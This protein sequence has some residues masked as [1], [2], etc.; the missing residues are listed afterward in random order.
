MKRNLLLALP[1]LAVVAL[2]AWWFR[3]PART[4]GSAF[5][6]DRS[7]TV[8]SSLAQ[9][10]RPLA[11]L[12]YGDKVEILSRRNENAQV[13]VHESVVGWVDGN[14]LM[15][16]ELWLKSAQLLERARALPLQSRGRTKVKTNLRAEPG[17]AAPRL[18]QFARG[19]PLEIVGRG[20][21]EWVPAADEKDAPEAPQESRK[22]DWFLVRGVAAAALGE[23]AARVDAPGVQ[24]ANEEPVPVAGWVVARFVELDL[25]D[26]VR[27]AAF[28]TDLRPLAW[29]ELN[30]VPDPSGD[31]PQYLVA[32][33]RGP[34]G[35]PCD[36]TAFRVF[37]WN[38]RRSR[39][40]TAFL[41]N[42]YCGSLPI[43]VGKSPKGEPE[44][45]FNAMSLKKEE[46]VFRLEQTIVRRVRT[47]PP[48]AV[49]PGRG[50]A[51]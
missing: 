28:A 19:V 18:Y 37:T 47:A 31:K 5:V 36:I 40:E 1:L 20:V 27:V 14:R 16:P 33:A 38:A 44:F 7:L 35:Q 15:G 2:L 30:R 29:F 26:A 12:H 41:G 17:R 45:R 4:L 32:G 6:S 49:S 23:P 8:Y 43:R 51:H 24:E 42:Q 21:A 10:R 22:E 9:V 48:R 13:R 3:P 39:Y 50:P 46:L 11:T 25:P 34:E